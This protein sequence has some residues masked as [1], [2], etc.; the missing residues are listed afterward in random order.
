MTSYF[1][2]LWYNFKEAQCIR[3]VT[4][5]WMGVTLARRKPEIGLARGDS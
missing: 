4:R 5:Q 2:G 1:G 3:V